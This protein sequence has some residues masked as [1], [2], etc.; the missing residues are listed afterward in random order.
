[1]TYDADRVLRLHQLV[2]L[3]YITVDSEHCKMMTLVSSKKTIAQS[4][5]GQKTANTNQYV[6]SESND[7]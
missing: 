2:H 4:M 7:W 5:S 6:W 1:M 3:A